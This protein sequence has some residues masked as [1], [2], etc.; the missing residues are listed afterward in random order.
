[1]GKMQERTLFAL[2]DAG[3]EAKTGMIS[4]YCRDGAPTERQLYSQRRAAR[5]IGAR[6]VRRE[7]RQWIWRLE[8]AECLPKPK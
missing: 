7:G 8:N 1:M 4:E 3:G 2:I 5:S 6:P